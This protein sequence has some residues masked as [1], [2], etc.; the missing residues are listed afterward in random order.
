MMLV[1]ASSFGRLRGLLRRYPGGTE[2]ASILRTVLRSSANTR[3][4]SRMLIPSTR[5][6][7]RTQAYNATRYI[8]PLSSQSNPD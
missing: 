4:A 2:N 3:E 8:S 5:H 6:A 7:R 1:N